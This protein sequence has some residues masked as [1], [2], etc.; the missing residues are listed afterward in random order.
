MNKIGDIKE[1]KVLQL[2]DTEYSTLFTKKFENRKPYVPKNENEVRAFMPGTV[3]KI[4]VKVGQEVKRGE[5]LLILESMK[6]MNRVRAQ[7]NGKIKAIGVNE[8]ESIPKN[9]LMIELE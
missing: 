6:M 4:L 3:K 1:W 9:H 8:G 2:W 7:K 5:T